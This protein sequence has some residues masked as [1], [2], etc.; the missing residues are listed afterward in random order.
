M[1]SVQLWRDERGEDAFRRC[2]ST[3]IDRIWF[4][5]DVELGRR[6]LRTQWHLS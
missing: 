2:L 5:K 6:D 3:R 4:L 1:K